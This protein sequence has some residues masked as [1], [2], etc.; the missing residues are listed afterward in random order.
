MNPTLRQLGRSPRLLR[1]RGTVAVVVAVSS[2]ALFAF[3]GIGL[4]AGRL[5]INKTELQ[6]AADACALA[7]AAELVCDPAVAGGCPASYLLR[8]QAAGIFVAAKNKRDFQLNSVVIALDAVKFNT[9]LA[10][11]TGY[12]SITGGASVNSKF[13][14]CTASAGGITPWFM[15]LVGAGDQGVTANAVATL[16]PGNSICPGAPIGVCPPTA[17]GSY[18]P[19]NWVVAQPTGAGN[20]TGLGNGFTYGGVIKGTFRWVDFDYPGGGTNEVRDRLAGTASVCGIG[21]A[22]TNIAE[23]GV[24]QGAK[25]A[26]NTR[27]GLYPTGG[28]PSAYT[29]ANA[30]PDHT[31]FAYPTK[32]SATPPIVVG[33]SAYAHFRSQQALGTPFQ[34]TGGGS[35][36]NDSPNP[37]PAKHAV[38]GNPSTTAEHLAYGGNRRL[39]A[40]PIISGCTGGGPVTIQSMACFLMLNPMANGSNAD[41]FME[42]RGLATA[43]GSPCA[44]GGSSGGPAS[45]GGLVPT[46]V[47]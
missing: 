6:S 43:A 17:G 41:V 10:P 7:A 23:E 33:T 11:N 12:L 44:S 9:V 2:L 36:Y 46:L 22:S 3:A 31:G 8:A 13:A 35:S 39:I 18:A 45:T 24:K 16:A 25:D 5:F 30:P 32:A 4:D 29:V 21:T 47:Q 14:M 34:G 19:G 28:G 42:Y 27:F 40:I 38:P 26:Y 20:T 15:T 37:P 1:Q